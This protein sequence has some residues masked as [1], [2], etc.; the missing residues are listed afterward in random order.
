MSQEINL[1]NPALIKKTDFLNP[2]T[3]GLL[4]GILLIGLL[5]YYLFESSNLTKLTQARALLAS[6][7]NALETQ[8]TQMRSVKAAQ[9]SNTGLLDTIK[10]LEEKTIMQEAIIKAVSQNNAQP[11]KS[12]AALLKAFSRQSIDGLWIT[13]LSIDQ[14]AEALSIKGRA[15]HADLLPTF[16]ARLRAE[17]ALKGKTF[18][19]L[20]MKNAAET[21]EKTETKPLE[22]STGEINKASNTNT[23]AQNNIP[24]Y[25]EFTLHSVTE[26]NKETLAASEV[27]H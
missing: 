19:D 27:A 11:S 12:Y 9:T 15:L 8:V 23:Q 16:I 25:I 24:P 5:G 14:D 3:I 22:T 2:N 21:Q 26:K 6:Q 13:G 4:L 20:K 17:P 18:T 1:L 7:V 10:Q